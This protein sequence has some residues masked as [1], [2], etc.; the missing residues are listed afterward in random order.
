MDL[1]LY[2][3]RRRLLRVRPGAEIGK[4]GDFFTN[5]SV[6]PVFGK[7]LARQFREMWLRLG[8]PSRFSL[9]EQG[10]NDGQ[11]ALDILSTLDEE[12]LAWDRVLDRRAVGHPSPPASAD[13]ASI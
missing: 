1:A 4:R 6:G 10:A 7:I 5:V 11:L 13:A 3:P 2:D 9:V 8:R 12:M